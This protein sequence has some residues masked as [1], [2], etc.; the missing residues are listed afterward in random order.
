[1]SSGVLLCVLEQMDNHD[2]A[3]PPGGDKHSMISTRSLQ[4]KDSLP[5]H[6]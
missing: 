4:Y 1:M 2:E 6:A 5:I 3:V